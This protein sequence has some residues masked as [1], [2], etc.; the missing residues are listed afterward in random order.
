MAQYIAAPLPVAQV[1]TQPLESSPPHH[2]IRETTYK[3]KFKI[4]HCQSRPG[5]L[6]R[7]TVQIGGQDSGVQLPLWIASGRRTGKTMFLSA[8]IHGDEINA[9]AIMQ[10][11][12]Q[13]QWPTPCGPH[14]QYQRLP[15]ADSDRARGR[16]GLESLFPWKCSRHRQRSNC[17]LHLF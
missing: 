8:G 14:C 6:A 3:P 2:P 13:T 12:V 17:S 11:F 9:I 16:K 1:Q 10:R 4:G 7:S 5:R 15:P